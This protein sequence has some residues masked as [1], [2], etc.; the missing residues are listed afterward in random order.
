MSIDSSLDIRQVGH[1][2]VTVIFFLGGERVSNC[3]PN[4]K[5]LESFLYWWLHLLSAYCIRC[6]ILGA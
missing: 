6:S 3:S 2:S 4:K 5:Q 1:H